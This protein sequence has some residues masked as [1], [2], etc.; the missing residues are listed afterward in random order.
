[1]FTKFK[2]KSDIVIGNTANRATGAGGSWIG[3]GEVIASYEGAVPREAVRNLIAWEPVEV[4]NANL[5]P[6]SLDEQFDTIVN[7]QAYQVLVRDDVKAIVRSDSH[8]SMGVFKDGYNSKGYGYYEEATRD[9]VGDL[10]YLAAGLLNGGRQF[11]FQVAMNEE[12]HDGLSGLDFMPYMMFQS[13]LDG[14]LANTWSPG[15]IIAKCDNM[16]PA[17]RKQSRLAGG[18]IKF[19]RSRFSDEKLGGLAAA[20]SVQRESTV[21]FAQSLVAV[22]VSVADYFKVL[23]REIPLPD[24]DKASKAAVTRAENTREAITGL[25]RSS[26]MVAQW[27]GTAFGVFQAFNTFNNREKAVRGANRIDRVFDRVLRGTTADEDMHV[28][29]SMQHVLGRELIA[30]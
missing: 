8:A 1:M 13:S 25:Y 9:A 23:D 10:P 22:K 2:G 19:K 14:S 4:P 26:P 24:A 29:S 12:Q 21:D 28:L 6:V 16:F 20:L 15:S 3:Q 27:N 17:I 11:F 7:G 18:Q 5:I 30:V